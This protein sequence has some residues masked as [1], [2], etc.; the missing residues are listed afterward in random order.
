[1]TDRNIVLVPHPRKVMWTNSTFTLT[2]DMVR[3]L[4]DP[5]SYTRSG[6]GRGV[7][8]FVDW[9]RSADV[10]ERG[11]RLIIDGD[12]IHLIEH[13]PSE[14]IL[15][16]F[17]GLRTL[18]QIFLQR[19]GDAL[20]FVEIEDHPAG[21]DGFARGY[22]LDISR[23][24]VPTLDTLFALVEKLAFLK[25]NQL[26][27]YTEHTFAYPGH[28]AVWRDASPL[29]AAEIRAL[30]AHCQE[31][32]IE[33]VPNQN[34]LGHMERWLKH[35]SYN[36]LAE[37]PDG[38][39]AP[40]G[41]VRSPSTLYPGMPESLDLVVELHRELRE[42]FKSQQVNI[43]CDEPWELGQGRSQERAD[44]VGVG[45]VYMEWI[46]KLYAAL[47]DGQTTVQMWGDIIANHPELVPRL[48]AMEHL[49]MFDWGY[50]ANHPF[51][52]RA[53]MYAEAGIP[54]VMVPGTSSWNAIVGRIDNMRGN[55]EGAIDAGIEHN[56]DGMLLTDWG[57]NGH[58][59]PYD[60]S[61]PAL[62]YAAGMAWNPDTNRD[63]DL[64]AALDALIYQ[65]GACSVG[66]AILSLGS[67]Y[68]MVGPEHINGQVLA[69]ILHATPDN[70]RER[71]TGVA[72]WGGSQADVSPETLRNVIAS[73][74]AN[75]GLLDQ[76]HPQ[77]VG[78]Q[79]SVQRWQ[80]AARLLQH[81]AKYLLWLQGT[82]DYT[83][84]AL[85]DE[86]DALIAAQR[87]TWLQTSRLGGL[88][89]SVAPLRRLREIYAE[90]AL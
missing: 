6:I 32:F 4:R 77:M 62:L 36:H 34:S 51:A 2:D 52:E 83:A 66:E 80:Q 25:Y 42:H 10:S 18:Q 78:G 15:G 76:A 5:Q 35:E 7:W 72:D 3:T 89:D 63:M 44:E 48:Q 38:F 21:V 8:Q 12:G 87:E 67:I 28:E 29:T 53:R 57:D 82:A 37:S 55:I 30:D 50:E 73:I 84:A 41:E 61:D 33:L 58:W 49:V 79:W 56:A 81:G 20:P 24:R 71:L 65:D 16:A 43:G 13:D 46:E 64:A 68:K 27:L 45:E 69:Y 23:D 59:Q 70:W 22:M 26:Q 54:R 39:T 11:Y 9:R 85:R 74:T 75:I 47:D 19:E 1:M 86:L 90:S 14:R 40:W 17:S 88:E 31:H 60:V